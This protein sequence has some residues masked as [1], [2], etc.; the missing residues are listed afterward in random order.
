MCDKRLWTIFV[1][2]L[3]VMSG[4]VFQLYRLQVVQGSE[5]RAR[6]QGQ[7]RFMRSS[8]AERGSVY[9]TNNNGDKVPV[10]VNSRVY[11]AYV[12]P[13]DIEEEK[14][15]GLA[16]LLAEILEVEEEY[17]KEKLQKDNAYER[18]KTN[19]TLEEVAAL[20][21]LEDAHTRLERVRHYPEAE[22]ASHVLGYFGGENIG[23][24]GV[25][26]YYEEMLKG[27]E[28]FREGIKIFN[29]DFIIHDS[30][31][32]GRDLE[33]T[34]DYNIQHFTERKLAEA[35]E[36]TQAEGGFVIVGNPHTGAITAVA[37][38]PDFD[39]N[40]FSQFDS[41]TLRNSA[42]QETFEPGSI[43]KPMV[44]AIALEEDKVRPDDIFVDQGVKYI[45]GEPIY[46]YERRNYG[47]LTMT[48][49]MEKSVNTGMVYVQR[50]LDKDVYIDHLK[51]FGFFEP[52]GIDLHGE[53]FSRNSNFLEG[54]E[55]NLATASYGQGIEINGMHIFSSF[56]TLANGGRAV[57]PF[58]L[59]KEGEDITTG[60]RIIS[61]ATSSLMT[62]MLV[63]TVDE[64]FGNPAKVSGYH[65][66][67]KTGTAQV[68]WSK[69]GV[70]R[71][72]YAPGA[73][74]QGFA[75]YAPAYEPEFVIVIKLDSPRTR[76]AGVSAAPVFRE[77]AEYIF[78]YKK[79]PHDYIY[80]TEDNT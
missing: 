49:V 22:L 80:D 35:V 63:S 26:Q 41:A 18:L 58:V 6:A 48:E 54:Y 2:M 13:R 25:E 7:Q 43:F 77:I 8:V 33:L 53:V 55:M 65:V 28:G 50:K 1:V 60:E 11:Y 68:A 78:E 52:T 38:Y 72:G 44:M 31:E 16:S 40:N 32:Q 76:S 46:N 39:P 66:A 74:V 57:Q 27:R 61:P 14:K 12:V 17:I 36:R 56:A 42:I 79:I 47:T 23:Q 29:R 62:D 9:L 37:N 4:I 75:G 45:R 69:L 21:D 19:L 3:L 70:N 64:G 71:R 73:T 59:K 5:W 10:A 20:K 24:Y 15:E 30:T 67:G 51:K 34:I